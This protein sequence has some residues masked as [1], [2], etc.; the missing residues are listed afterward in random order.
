M[1]D[2]RLRRPLDGYGGEAVK[3]AGSP[4]AS[5]DAPKLVAARCGFA[6]AATLRRAFVRHVGVTPAGYR[7]RH[8]RF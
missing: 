7:Q 2:L 8:E 4:A 3:I 1:G 6:D 5:L